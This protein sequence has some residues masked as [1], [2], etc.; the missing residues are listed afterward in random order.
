M[1]FS[2]WVLLTSI[3]LP[4]TIETIGVRVFE[5]CSGLITFTVPENVA[6]IESDAFD[7]ATH[8]IE[9]YNKSSPDITAIHVS[10]EN[11]SYLSMECFTIKRA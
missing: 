4:D 10:A 5:N 6:L 8:L 11:K 3:T 7:G 2:G 9:V 1:A